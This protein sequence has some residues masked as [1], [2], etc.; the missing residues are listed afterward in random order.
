MVKK[1]QKQAAAEQ[2]A[3]A[4]AAAALAA[5]PK[6]NLSAKGMARKEAAKK[7]QAYY[8]SRIAM[9][10]VGQKRRPAGRY[11]PLRSYQQIQSTLVRGPMLSK[12]AAIDFFDATKQHENVIHPPDSVGH[13]LR[14]NQISS[15][16][17]NGIN[18]TD[19]YIVIQ[20][21]NFGVSMFYWFGNNR[22]INVVYEQDLL[23]NPPDSIRQSRR[24]IKILNHTNSLSCQG[25]IKIVATSNFLNWEFDT[26]TTPAV[27]D[28]STNFVAEV[29]TILNSSPDSRTYSASEFQTG[30]KMVSSIIS[31]AAFSEWTDFN[32]SFSA[33]S[34]T[35]KEQLLESAAR[36][37]IQSTTIIKILNPAVAQNY[38]IDVYSEYS[39]RYPMNQLMSHL[40]AQINPKTVLTGPQAQKLIQQAEAGRN[41]LLPASA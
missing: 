4:A 3:A 40:H 16:S 9:R 34:V 13:F 25:A 29:D 7:I 26:V 2:A 5:M 17:L 1:D 24:T 30:K 20:P 39:C 8:K 6:S 38:I 18:S 33:S 21:N 11:M 10:Y 31:M 23:N 28:V 12:Q 37:M 36:Q 27:F 35:V 15:Q 41:V 22:T 14:L 19:T 32:S